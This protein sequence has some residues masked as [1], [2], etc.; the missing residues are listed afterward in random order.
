MEQTE[1]LQ[2]VTLNYEK[3]EDLAQ[4][5]VDTCTLEGAST[6]T[7]CAAFGIILA[8]LFSHGTEAH[9]DSELEIQFV[10]D[11]LDYAGLYFNEAEDVN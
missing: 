7:A 4:Q 8:R 6:A 3:V 10:Q 2:T 9:G 5:I 11:L 1:K